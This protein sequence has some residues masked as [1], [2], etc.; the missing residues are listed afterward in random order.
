M[1]Q[2]A[3]TA[4]YYVI[5]ID[6]AGQQ[7]L[8]M[9]LPDGFVQVMDSVQTLDTGRRAQYDVDEIHEEQKEREMRNKVKNTCGFGIPVT[10]MPHGVPWQ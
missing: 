5:G 3:N 4:I 1:N 7:G 2:R 9:V 10:P 8:M 6:H